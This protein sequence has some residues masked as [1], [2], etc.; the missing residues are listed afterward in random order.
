MIRGPQI[1]PNA[2]QDSLAVITIDIA[3][4]LL[5]ISGLKSETYGMDGKSLW[6]LMTGS[7]IQKASRSFLIEYHGEGGNGNDAGCEPFID[8]NVAECALDWGCKCQD[9]KNNTYGCLRSITDDEDS[10]YC[11]FD[12]DKYTTELYDMNNDPFQLH[13]LIIDIVDDK[14]VDI[15]DVKIANLNHLQKCKGYQDCNAYS[16]T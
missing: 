12:D 15:N 5:D 9:A 16:N 3:P 10:L 8:E 14:V 11:K 7:G 4:T 1:T 6:P 2:A 13:N